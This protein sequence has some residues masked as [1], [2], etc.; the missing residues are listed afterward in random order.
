MG[1]NKYLPFLA[2]KSENLESFWD[3]SHLKT[4]SNRANSNL[5]KKVEYKMNKRL[6][7]MW[8]SLIQ[9]SGEWQIS[10]PHFTEVCVWTK[11][12]QA[13]KPCMSALS[14]RAEE[15]LGDNYVTILSRKGCVKKSNSPF[16]ICWIFTNTLINEHI[17]KIITDI[18]FRLHWDFEEIL[19]HSRKILNSHGMQAVSVVLHHNKNW[20]R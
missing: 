8:F 17:K 10:H 6:L 1:I 7:K 3:Y 18:L 15:N 19:Q 14:I 4:K 9:R 2:I 5:L 20:L 16:L 12:L 13:S 11:G